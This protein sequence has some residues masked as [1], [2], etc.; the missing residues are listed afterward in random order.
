MFSAS[1]ERTEWSLPIGD[2]ARLRCRLDVGFL[3]CGL[4]QQQFGELTLTLRRG[5]ALSLYEGARALLASLPLRLEA[6]SRAVRGYAMRTPLRHAPLRAE[7]V[8]LHAAMP[9]AQVMTR[10]VLNCLKQ[11]TGNVPLVI[12]AHDVEALHQLRVGVRRLRAGADL[13]ASWRPMAPALLAELDWLGSVLGPARDWDVLAGTT[14]AHVASAAPHQADLAQLCA[15]AAT[16]AQ[17][18]HGAVVQ[19]LKDER[20]TSL[21]LEVLRWSAMPTTDSMAPARALSSARQMLRRAARKLARRGQALGE[22]VAKVRHRV[23]I[24]AKKLRYALEFFQS[25]YQAGKVH[26]LIGRLG[27]FQDRLGL[28]N[29]AAI[30]DGLLA[31]LCAGQPALNEAAAFARGFITAGASVSDS[32][33]SR[34]LHKINTSALPASNRRA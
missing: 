15:A 17:A 5:S 32:E 26:A 8:K 11:I 12:A 1:V 29:D 24:A 3:V 2:A 25:L 19:A 10:V 13:F 22:D 4:A 28:L 31:Q 34:L 18:Q 33:L 9:A 27:A 20:F 6:H 30:A 7:P 14:L 21:L 23:R 16:K